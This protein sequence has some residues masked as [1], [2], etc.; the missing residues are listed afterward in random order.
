MLPS[1]WLNEWQQWLQHTKTDTNPWADLHEILAHVRKH[2]QFTNASPKIW[3]LP[4]KKFWEQ[5]RAKFGAISDTFPLW[6]WI[7]PERIEI[8]KIGKLFDRQHSLPRWAKKL[9]EL[10]STNHGDLEVQLYPQQNRLFR[11]TISRP[12]VKHQIAVA[13]R[14]RDFVGNKISAS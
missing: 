4:L 1:A 6:V 2:V 11:N 3:G 12:T 5:K 13:F 10:W 7:S 14:P 9:G 8:S